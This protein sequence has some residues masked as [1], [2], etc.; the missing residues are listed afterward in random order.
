MLRDADARHKAKLQ[1][2][3]SIV[4]HLVLIMYFEIESV[5]RQETALAVRQPCV[6]LRSEG[7]IWARRQLGNVM[8][9]IIRDSEGIFDCVLNI[10]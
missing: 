1:I 3:S 10:V 4:V 5:V 9:E 6:E 2:G 8:L 7:Q